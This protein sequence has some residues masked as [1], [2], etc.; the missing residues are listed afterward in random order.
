MASV[1]MNHVNAIAWQNGSAIC[2]ARVVGHDKEVLNQGSLASIVRSVF[3]LSDDPDTPVSGPTTLSITSSMFNSLQTG[4]GWT[5]D[6]TGYNFRDQIPSSI[7]T[8]H[9][10]RY[11]VEYKFTYLV[12]VPSTS[13]GFVQFVFNLERTYS[14]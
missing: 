6:L 9:G 7:L 3:D 1:L 5:A 14:A 10:H 4:A 2:M 13:V 12:T 8:V 11:L